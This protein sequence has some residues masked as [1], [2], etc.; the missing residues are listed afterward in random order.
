LPPSPIATGEVIHSFRLGAAPSEWMTRHAELIP[1]L[2][3]RYA[4]GT[5]IAGVCS[6]V[7]FL[8]EAGLLDGRRATTY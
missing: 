8:A 6:G 4:D 1:W 2:S 5:L 7:A 3:D